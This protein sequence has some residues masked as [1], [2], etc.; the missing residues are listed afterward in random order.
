MEQKQ[1]LRQSESAL[2]IISD[3]V[4]VLS[5]RLEDLLFRAQRIAHALKKGQKVQDMMFGYDLQNYRRDLRLFANELGALGPALGR[6]ERIACFSEE[7]FQ[8]AQA[9]MRLSERLHKAVAALREQALLAHQHIRSSEHKVEAWYLVQEVE[10]LVAL[11]QSLPSVA[12]RIVIQVGT[13]T[14]S[15]APTAPAGPGGFPSNAPTN[16]PPRPEA[17]PL[18]GPAVPTQSLGELQPP[19]DPDQKA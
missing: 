2:S 5:S 4:S 18:P 10:A 14:A 7:D 9:V 11:A 17:A 3:R 13:P 19:P 8:W 6:I 12:N 16:P 15:A 1:A